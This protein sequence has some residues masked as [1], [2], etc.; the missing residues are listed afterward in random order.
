MLGRGATVWVWVSVDMNGPVDGEPHIRTKPPQEEP[1]NSR[2][3]ARENGAK[4]SYPRLSGVCYN[5]RSYENHIYF[6]PKYF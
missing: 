4:K 6:T 5:I 1:G 3:Q 2:G